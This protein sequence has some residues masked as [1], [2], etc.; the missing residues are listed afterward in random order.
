MPNKPIRTIPPAPPVD[1]ERLAELAR[2]ERAA[3]C[4]KEMQEVLKRHKCALRV[5]QLYVNATLAEQR[6]EVVALT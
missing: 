1:P 6:I 4:E 5:V 2:A 3:R